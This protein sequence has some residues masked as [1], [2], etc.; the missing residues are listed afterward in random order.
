METWLA[1]VFGIGIG[2]VL[3]RAVAARDSAESGAEPQG[4]ALHRLAMELREF[5]EAMP[6]DDLRAHPGFQ[7][8][9]ALLRASGA[10]AEAL[11]RYLLTENG[12]IASMALEVVA[13]RP[14]AGERTGLLLDALGNAIPYVRRF[15]L[16]LL[17]RLAERPVL[18]AV[19]EQADPAF[20]NPYLHDGLVQLFRSRAAVEAPPA[21]QVTVSPMPQEKAGWW[22]AFVRG[23]ACPELEPLAVALDA[24]ARGADGP[25]ARDGAPGAGARP[26]GPESAEL[27]EFARVLTPAD[28]PE[29]V[30]RH[31]RF[32]ALLAELR[33]H[34]TAPRPRSVVVVGE[35]GVGKT[36]AIEALAAEL[37]AEGWLVFRASGSELNAGMQYVGTLEGRVQRMLATVAAHGRALW[38]VPDL[39]DLLWAGMTLHGPRGVL[40]L[41]VPALADGR[42]VMLAESEPTAW[43]R[44]LQERPALREAV[45]ALAVEPLDRA[46]TLELAAAFVARWSPAEGPPLLGPEGLAEAFALAQHF[47]DTRAAPGNLLGF[48]AELHA[49][50]LRAGAGTGAWSRDDLLGSLARQSGLPLAFLDERRSIDLAQAR[51]TFAGAVIGQPEA[52]ECLVDRLA[53][54]KAGLGDPQRP[55]GVFLFTGPTGT[56]KTELARTLAAWLFGSPE[57]LVRLDMSEFQ[58]E[59]ALGAI[60][61]D[62]SVGSGRLALVDQIRRQPF[63]VVLLDEFEK[64]HP[65]VWD[66][67]LQVFDAGRLT[68]RRGRRADFRHAIV[69]LTANVGAEAAGQGV[70]FAAGPS[71]AGQRAATQR[72]LSRVFRPEFL[73]RLDRVVVFRPLSRDVMRRVLDKELALVLQRR[74]LRQRNWAIEWDA[75]ALEFLLDRGFSPELGA[76]PLRRAIEHHLL[77]PLARTMVEHRVP[78]GDQFLMVRAA[79]GQIEVEFVD[80]DAGPAPVAA[81]PAPA[82]APPGLEGI[83]LDAR[84]TAAEIAALDGGLRELRT[85]VDGPAWQER[86][87]ALLAR[88]GEAEFWTSSDRFAVLGEVEAMERIRAGV[89]RAS[90]FF[91]RLRGNPAH[92]RAH[93]APD[94]VAGLALKL[95]MLRGELD[96]LLAGR[97]RDAFVQVE[98]LC[99]PREDGS[100][101][102]AFAERLVAMYLRWAERRGVE[103]RV[104][105]RS[106]AGDTVP[107]RAVLG[108]SGYAA[109]PRLA[110]EHGLHVLESDGEG[111]GRGARQR[112]RVTVV[113][114]PHAPLP[115]DDAAAARVA[116]GV[117]DA[118]GELSATI[119]RRYRE[120]GSPLVRDAVRGW[121]TGRLDR[122]LAGDFDLFT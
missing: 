92:P 107:L 79:R 33:A 104:L 2:A 57:R 101:A 45:A 111:R 53:L 23:V 68:D 96:A 58:D 60:L 64:A 27:R 15:A 76:R 74:G 63:A 26:A 116:R 95:L 51:A 31:A 81:A 12:I 86:K 65:R 13:G 59:S 115:A 121:R 16:L 67:F 120:E 10:D 98:A 30:H 52:V 82:A 21:G 24:A 28:A 42:L 110:G 32:A 99:D 94:P 75:S 46:A 113:P 20:T 83:V 84:G 112:V 9:V 47:L 85:Q 8:G 73:N 93:A 5:Y 6:L 39:Q 122:V 109:H 44:T 37:V 40:D 35:R 55:Q 14:A 50:R 105:E 118:A 71:E 70:G 106:R 80:P 91:D 66:L 89:E 69:I 22:A 87:E 119:V 19:I 48:L 7:R 17:A 18:V 72:A 36:L 11:R 100:M 62:G 34:V 103:G 41:V 117:L 38:L 88:T 29:F 49:A 114:Q 90:R 77:A 3:A 25:E 108:L 102:R 97:L 54:L 4:I 61:G 78:S 56:G 1:I 43:Q